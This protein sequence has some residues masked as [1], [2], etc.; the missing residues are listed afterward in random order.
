MRV[1]TS[2][3]DP[4]RGLHKATAR[5]LLVGKGPSSGHRSGHQR[6]P[7][8]LSQMFFGQSTP[9]RPVPGRS[10]GR[11]AL[12][13]N[14]SK[15]CFLATSQTSRNLP[16][17]AA[18]AAVPPHPPFVLPSPCAGEDPKEAKASD[19]VSVRLIS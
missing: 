10:R 7:L 11:A 17:R 6:P 19:K 15:H 12:E 8:S 1:V 3:S 16:P 4:T 5:W 13:P 18:P 14:I 2:P 9:S